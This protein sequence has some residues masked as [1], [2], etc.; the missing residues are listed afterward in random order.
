[1]THQFKEGKM[2]ERERAV[3]IVSWPMMDAIFG[4]LY[5]SWNPRGLCPNSARAVDG[6][7]GP[8]D[9]VELIHVPCHGRSRFGRLS[10]A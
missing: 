10:A 4:S 6:V 5:V 8:S 1:M 2:T 9:I 3:A 7:V